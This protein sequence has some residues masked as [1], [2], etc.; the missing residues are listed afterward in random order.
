MDFPTQ[1]WVRDVKSVIFFWFKCDFL[2]SKQQMC[3][4]LHDKTNS[5]KVCAIIKNKNW[6]KNHKNGKYYGTSLRKKR[7]YFSE[8]MNLTKRKPRYEPIVTA[9]IA[10]KRWSCARDGKISFRQK[11]IRFVWIDTSHEDGNMKK[12]QE[13]ASSIGV[14]GVQNYSM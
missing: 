13:E 12:N 2:R 3:W 1:Y 9:S 14:N 6:N 11:E 8:R 4:H 5:Q 7:R 10:N